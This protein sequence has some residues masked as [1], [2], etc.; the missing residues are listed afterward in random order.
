[1]PLENSLSLSKD[2]RLGVGMLDHR[3]AD[4]GSGCEAEEV[5]LGVGVLDH[6]A[7]DPGSGCGAEE[8]RLGVGVLDHRAAVAFLDTRA[9]H[10]GHG[11][12]IPP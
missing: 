2:L 5:R 1:M 9:D 7:A 11:G 8:V 12:S 10:V 4:P 6:R 3:A